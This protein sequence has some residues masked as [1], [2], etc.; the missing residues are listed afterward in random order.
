MLIMQTR[1]RFLTTLSLAGA[2]GL[3]RAP[4]SLAAEGALE[5][6]R[7]RIAK[8]GAICLAPQYAGEGFTEIHYVEVSPIDIPQ[9]IGRGEA[10]FSTTLAV[11]LIHAIDDGAPSTPKHILRT[12]AKDGR[13]VGRPKKGSTSRCTC[14]CCGMP[15]AIITPTAAKIRAPCSSGWVIGPFSILCGIRN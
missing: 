1:R 13:R 6:T 5:T 7:I 3:L 11:D 10:D 14:T 2:A 12:V 4:P 8:I 9:A 15:A